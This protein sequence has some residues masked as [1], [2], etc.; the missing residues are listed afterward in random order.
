MEPTKESYAELQ[1]A[2]DHFNEHLFGRQLPP[3]LITMQ[4]KRSTYGYFSR[5]RFINLD[6]DRTDEI[7]MNPTYFAVCP[8]RETLQ[9]LVHEMTHLWQCRFGKAGR[10]RY[11]NKEWGAKMESIGLMPSHDGK[12]GGRKTGEKMAD[13]MIVGGPFEQA[14]QALLETSFQIS[15]MDRFP[16][17]TRLSEALESLVGDDAIGIHLI[18]DCDADADNLDDNPFVTSPNKSNRS[19]FQCPGCSANAWGKPSLN[20]MCGNCNVSFESLDSEQV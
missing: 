15:W 3:C 1:L 10:G 17:A 4:R 9:T 18:R 13:Y 2:F 16:D 8:L 5:D 14:F 19:K 12:P 7:A 11:H 6:G 20:L